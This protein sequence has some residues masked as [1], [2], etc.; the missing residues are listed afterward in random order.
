M[1]SSVNLKAKLDRIFSLYIRLR[2]SDDNGYGRCIS[3]R[4]IVHYKDADAGHFINRKHMSLRYDEKNVN[5]QCRP[6]NRFDEGNMTG[7][8][9]GLI[10]KYGEDVIKYLEVKKY[11]TSKICRTVYLELIKYYENKVKELQN[12]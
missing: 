12:G 9:R 5:F 11:N 4:K 7:Y 6:C 10:C 2:D 1:K 8:A 3:C